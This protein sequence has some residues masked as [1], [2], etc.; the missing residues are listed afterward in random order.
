M[1]LLQ[2]A[3]AGPQGERLAAAHIRRLYPV[4]MIDEFQDTD[5]RQFDIFNRIYP[6]AE[7][8]ESPDD[9]HHSLIMIG[10]PKQA[11]YAFRGVPIF[12]PTFKRGG[13]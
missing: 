2:A 12:L 11:I 9:Q 4:A 5:A 1:R 13:I 3:L 7:A 10:D 8:G 6:P